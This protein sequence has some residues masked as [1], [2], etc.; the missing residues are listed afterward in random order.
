[1]PAADDL[2]DDLGKLRW[3]GI[4]VIAGMAW[5]S[6]LCVLASSLAIGGGLMPP[7]MAAMLTAFP[8]YAAWRGLDDTGCRVALGVTMPLYCAIL[9]YQWTGHPW[10]IDLHM[11]FFAMIAVLAALADWRPV[12]AGAAVAAVHHLALNFLAPAMV[13]GATG[14]FGRVVLHAGVVVVE[15]GILMVLANRLESLLRA[16]AAARRE[17]EHLEASARSE[18]EARESEQRLVVSEI[19]KGLNALASGDLECPITTRFPPAFE[20]LRNDFNRSID[21]LDQLIASV[22]GASGQI[23]IGTSEIRTAAEDLAHR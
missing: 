5:L 1:V 11:A 9:L 23:R 16:Q 3:Q 22:A 18:R 21:S 6:L 10:Q 8:T 7:V 15:T 14:D 2:M 19:G 12:L 4:G 13:F 17:R 20:E